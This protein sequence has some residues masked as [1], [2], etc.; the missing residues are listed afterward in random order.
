MRWHGLI[1]CITDGSSMSRYRLLQWWLQRMAKLIE[2]L[3]RVLSHTSFE[4]R[5]LSVQYMQTACH[6]S[7]TNIQLFCFRS[8]LPFLTLYIESKPSTLIPLFKG[9]VISDF[10]EALRF[11]SISDCEDRWACILILTTQA[12]DSRYGNLG[13]IYFISV[14]LPLSE[15][16]STCNSEQ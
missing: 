15:L 12:W 14:T 3:F 13:S 1:H 2:V 8:T 6:L 16:S 7:L 9:L 5:H 10:S 4:H 11:F